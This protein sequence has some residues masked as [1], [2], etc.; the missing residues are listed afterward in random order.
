VC[1][2]ADG[3]VVGL[4]NRYKNG[5]PGALWKPY[6]NYITLFYPNS[7]LFNQYVHLQFEGGFVLPGIS[8]KQGSPLVWQA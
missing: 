2:A 1:A 3:L 6:G 7:G 8:L 4:E 5:N